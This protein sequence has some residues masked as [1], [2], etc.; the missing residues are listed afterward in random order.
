MMDRPNPV[1]PQFNSSQ[2]LLR[3][4]FRLVILSTF[5]TLSTQRFGTALVALLALAAVFCASMAAVRREAVLSP[6][7]TYWDEA[8]AYG[9]IGHVVFVLA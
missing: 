3:F 6:E 5:A 7:L 8:A 2:V 1:F 9:L 4:V